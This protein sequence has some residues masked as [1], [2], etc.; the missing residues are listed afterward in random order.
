MMSPEERKRRQREASERWTKAHPEEALARFRRYEAAHKEARAARRKARRAAN[1]G[2]VRV[3][4]QA[5]RDAHRELRR[6]WS[7]QAQRRSTV[8]RFGIDYERVA[9]AQ[10]GGC[11]V[12]SS[13]PHPR[14]RLA[15]DHD[16]ATGAFR[17]L[18][19]DGCNRALGFV[20]DDISR[21]ERL[22]VY[23]AESRYPRAINDPV[24]QG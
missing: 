5:W 23:L 4:E 16:H 8:K 19:C 3:K 22:I 12:C 1:L 20:R 15:I 11:A 6:E 7:R 9:A 21:L 2:A 17:G 14:K 24:K 18:L 10:G 13:K